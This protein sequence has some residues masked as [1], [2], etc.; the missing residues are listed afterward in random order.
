MKTKII[1][2]SD[3][4]KCKTHNTS[5]SHWIPEHKLQECDPKAFELAVKEVELND[6]PVEL[7]DR[8]IL[9]YKKGGK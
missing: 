3:I 1:N 8:I 2:L 4:A 6:A 5:P 7:L 9:S